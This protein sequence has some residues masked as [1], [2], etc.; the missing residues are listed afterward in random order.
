MFPLANMPRLRILVYKFY[1]TIARLTFYKLSVY[2]EKYVILKILLDLI[3]FYCVHCCFS[4]P[5]ASSQRIIYIKQGL[6][7]IFSLGPHSKFY[8]PQSLLLY[9]ESSSRQ[10]VL[11]YVYICKG[12]DHDQNCFDFSNCCQSRLRELV[13]DREAWRAIVHGVAKS[14]T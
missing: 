10:Q 9:G 8:G 7:N 14:Q 5:S 4:L 3:G 6:A 1:F 12:R 11:F 13:M 2:S